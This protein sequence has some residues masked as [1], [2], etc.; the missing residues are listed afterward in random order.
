MELIWIKTNFMWDNSIYG[1]IQGKINI[2]A[3]P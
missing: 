1:D 3:K 2:G